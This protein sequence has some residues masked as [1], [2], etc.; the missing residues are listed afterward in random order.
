LV[1]LISFNEERLVFG[2]VICHLQW[3]LA[4]CLVSPHDGGALVLK[5]E[6]TEIRRRPLT[7]AATLSCATRGSSLWLARQLGP[8]VS[9]YKL[10]CRRV[11]IAG[12]ARP[13][14]GNVH[15]DS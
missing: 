8:L 2:D 4:G 5:E 11:R 9:H 1:S 14:A 12:A 3:L 15:S 6:H 10:N 13:R 7:A